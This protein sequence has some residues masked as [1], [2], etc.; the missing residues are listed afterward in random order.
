M[1]SLANAVDRCAEALVVPSFS[2]LGA[3]VRRRLD[4]WRPLDT[5]DLTGR[6]AL[7][8]GATSGLGRHTATTLADLG[9]TVI[10]SARDIDKAERTRHGLLTTSPGATIDIAVGDLAVPD[11][12][13]ALGLDERFCRLWRIYLAY[14]EAAFAERHCTLEQL[15]FTTSGG[16]RR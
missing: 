8:T 4:D 16:P 11:D 1:T 5:Y 7:V 10:V 12:V 3:D 2:R 15:V 14:C 13:R 9:A 6:V